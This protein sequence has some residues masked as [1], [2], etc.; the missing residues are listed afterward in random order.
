MADAD[1]GDAAWTRSSDLGPDRSVWW[2]DPSP[3]ATLLNSDDPRWLNPM[4]SGGAV[5][6]WSSTLN[7]NSPSYRTSASQVAWRGYLA[8]KPGDGKAYRSCRVTQSV[9]ADLR[10]AE[11][12]SMNGHH[13]QRLDNR[14]R[15]EKQQAGKSG[16][17]HRSRLRR[18]R[19]SKPAGIAAPSACLVGWIA[20]FT[21]LGE[22][23]EGGA[24]M[25]RGGQ[26]LARYAARRRA[27]R[28]LS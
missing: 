21:P 18:G 10:R 8:D 25:V 11:R 5:A 2:V 4:F 12:G 16:S 7:A 20:A 14:R 1:L 28:L 22:G 19:S 23:G 6:S 26:H 13:R 15:P 17:R 9:V 3:V 27:G 24:P